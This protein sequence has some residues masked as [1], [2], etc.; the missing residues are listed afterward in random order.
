MPRLE[1][2]ETVIA[3]ARDGRTYLPL[4][5]DP[6]TVWDDLAPFYRKAHM[7]W[8]DATKRKPEVQVARIAEVVGLMKAGVKIRD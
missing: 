7:R 6:A 3:T 2:F 8:I 1:H 5:F 4:P